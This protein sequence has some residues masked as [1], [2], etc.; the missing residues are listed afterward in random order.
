M[1]KQLDQRTECELLGKLHV[2][3]HKLP[4][5]HH[6][7]SGGAHG[8]VGVPKSHGADQTCAR[9]GRSV[10]ARVTGRLDP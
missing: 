8:H 3:I 7:Q 9:K 10:F 5:L 1:L 2:V 6:Q 4:E